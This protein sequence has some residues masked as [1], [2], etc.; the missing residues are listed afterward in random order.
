MNLDEL[1]KDGKLKPHKTSAQEIAD[2]LKVAERDLLDAA[3][4]EL[5]TD[6]RFI[7]AY[8]AILQLSTIV[9]YASGYKTYGSGHHYITFQA[10]KELLPAGYMQLMDYFDAC[11]SKRNISDYDRSGI[12]SNQEA[13]EILAEA[14]K[15]KKIVINWLKH[16]HPKL[17]LFNNSKDK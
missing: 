12:I 8:N 13:N 11:R 15:F 4:E 16:T 10:L 9:L 17:I 3:I 1:V 7:I 6:R 14:V 5:S 2:L